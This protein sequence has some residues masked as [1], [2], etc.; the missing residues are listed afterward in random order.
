MLGYAKLSVSLVNGGTVKGGSPFIYRANVGP[1]GVVAGGP[2][3]SNYVIVPG[4][5]LL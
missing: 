2:I 4:D 3:D 5:I 1:N